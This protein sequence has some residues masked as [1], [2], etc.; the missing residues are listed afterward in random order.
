MRKYLEFKAVHTEPIQRYQRQVRSLYDGPKGAFLATASKLS[1]H[2][3]LM[4]GVFRRREYDVST[5]RELLDLGCGAGQIVGHLLKC[6]PPEAQVTACDLSHRMLTRARTR[7]GQP[8]RVTFATADIRHLPFGD[9]RFDS[10]SC[11][12]VLEYL[13]DPR[14][15]LAE[16]ARVLKPGG[17]TL[18]F[19]TENTIPG[20]L[21]SHTW[22]CRT[23]S[24]AEFRDACRDAGLEWRRELWFSPVHRLLRLGG[25]LVEARKPLAPGL[26]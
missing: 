9:D 6:A 22:K 18:L 25:I 20:F 23:F 14:P 1:L 17:K 24:R 13:P 10:V 7:L 21:T 15:A 8:P 2:E 19:V 3:P 16:I 4:G 12:L 26:I 11:G 5:C